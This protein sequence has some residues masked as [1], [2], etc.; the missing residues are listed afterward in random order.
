MYHLRDSLYLPHSPEI[1]LSEIIILPSI[2]H[3]YDT[4][5]HSFSLA[6]ISN[7]REITA[8]SRLSHLTSHRGWMATGRHL[9][10]ERNPT[11][12]I[13]REK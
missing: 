3:S 6:S 11:V 8:N 7:E 10:R 5:R 2:I 13:T 9:G 1:S 4:H 12:E